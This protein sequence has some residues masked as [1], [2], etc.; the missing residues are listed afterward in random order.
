MPAH[1]P[2]RAFTLVELLVVMGIIA[3]LIG[4]VL[5]IS[6]SV[7]NNAKTQDTKVM[8]QTLE[9]AIQAFKDDAPLNKVS[10]YNNRYAGGYPPD[11]MEAISVDDDFSSTAP[12]D[13]VL[14]L[15]ARLSSDTTGTL[16]PW[17][18]ALAEPIVA[19]NGDLIAMALAIKLY[20]PSASSLLDKLDP[21]FRRSLTDPASGATAKYLDKD[22]G[23]RFYEPMEFFVDAWGTPIDYFATSDG[24]VGAP[25][26]TITD[27]GLFVATP[28]DRRLTSAALIAANSGAPL[29]V[30]YGPDGPDQFAADFA[31]SAQVGRPHD[32]VNDWMNWDPA[33]PPPDPAID[34]PLNQ[35][36]IY[37]NPDIID[38]L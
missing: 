20:S 10:G 19:K 37:S 32:M 33:V 3:V 11:E 6:S 38:R 18:T 22:G 16:A 15:N 23:G 30:S 21:R 24:T 8:L 29:F 7:I 4:A 35:D 26:A 14:S 17:A 12:F 34:H 13:P 9:L 1:R 36:N 31:D 5:G 27:A 2:I 28:G 25:E